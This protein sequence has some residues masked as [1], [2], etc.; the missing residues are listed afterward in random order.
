MRR[1]VPVG[2]EKETSILITKSASFSIVVENKEVEDKE[3]E[4]ESRLFFR[5]SSS[6][7]KTSAFQ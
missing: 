6:S 4:G 5:E 7:T 2:N 1:R 3:V